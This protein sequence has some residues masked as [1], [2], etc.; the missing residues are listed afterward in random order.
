M[1]YF[2]Y[3]GMLGNYF[4]YKLAKNAKNFSVVFD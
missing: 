2:W 4:L 3:G 1:N